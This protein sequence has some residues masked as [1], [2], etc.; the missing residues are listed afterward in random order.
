[1][2][3]AIVHE[4]LVVYAGSER[5]L[6]QILNLFPEADLYAVVDF[7]PY[8]DRHFL[9]GRAPI[10][11]FIQKLPFA[12]TRFR[13]YLGL[14]PLAIEQ[15]DL[16]AYDLVISSSHAV[17]KGVLTGPKQT[18]ISYVHS[19]VRY[20]WDLHHE[21]LREAG[22]TS[23]LKSILAKLTLHYLRMWDLRTINTVDS[24]VANSA[25]VAQRIQK[26]YGRTA[27][28]VHPPVDTE[29]FEFCN[30]KEQYYL[31]ASRAVPYKRLPLL[32]EAFNAMPERKLILV[33]SGPEVKAL[34]KMAGANVTVLEQQPPESLRELM[35]KAKAFV[36][37]AEEDFGIT[38]AEA[39]AC[40]TPV[41]AY[42]SGGASE[43]V[44]DL[45]SDE[46]TGVLFARQTVEEIKAAI[47]R[48]ESRR[49]RIHPYACRR[50]SERFSIRRFREAFLAH[51][52]A[53]IEEREARPGKTREVSLKASMNTAT[54]RK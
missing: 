50:N 7:L 53:V 39:Q 54:S 27:T 52:N 44:R 17:A 15:L 12:K 38:L 32:V 14:M 2:R 40:G 49:D 45:D 34:R 16:S 36:F 43:I 29:A 22:L 47:E 20:A 51:C 46:P 1:M 13:Q 24:F 5:V 3:V 4:W 31:T 21:Y 10:T 25:F 41:I 28:V 19:P 30:E 48:F 37:A 18:H 6:E 11:T 33:T 42:E 23:G 9:G 35:Q 26:F 8:Q